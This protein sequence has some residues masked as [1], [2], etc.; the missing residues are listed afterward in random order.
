M[1]VETGEI[2]VDGE[3]A[4]DVQPRLEDK[5]AESRGPEKTRSFFF[6]C[7]DGKARHIAL[8][9]PETVAKTFRNFKASGALNRVIYVRTNLLG[10]SGR[11]RGK[12]FRRDDE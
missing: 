7:G 5:M 4:V 12:R 2:R 11:P 6:L 9:R 1:H 10:E 3:H 8:E